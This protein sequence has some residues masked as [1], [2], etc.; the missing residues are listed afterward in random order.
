VPLLI[1]DLDGTLIDSRLDLAHS[2]NAARAEM[3]M[4]P[5]AHEIVYSYV[6]NG[7]P[8]L[9]ERAMGKDATGKVV[10]R[11]LEFF[12]DYYN[13]HAV[14]HTEL[15]PGVLDSL[16]QLHR[17]GNLLAV[18]TNKPVRI[19]Q[20]IVEHFGLAPLIARTYGGNSFEHK[21]PHPIGID[22]L[23]SELNATCED[24]WMIGD[25][26]V[27]V[28]TARNA[29][30]RV[31]GVTYGFQPDTLVEFPP[32]LLVDKIEDFAARI[33]RQALPPGL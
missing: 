22:T 23:R 12:L 26:Y 6:G 10:A 20:S 8:V 9:I 2:V 33:V 28:Q 29:R 14:D 13:H 1:F 31:C 17:A 7:A 24:T 11:A 21:K 16:K 3:G 32:D 18:L 15:Y 25:S 19:S 27:D 30:V 4:G 5:L